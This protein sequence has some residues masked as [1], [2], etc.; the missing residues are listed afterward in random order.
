LSVTH[1]FQILERSILNILHIFQ[2]LERSILKILIN[3]LNIEQR[4]ER[5]QKLF[6]KWK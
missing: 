4:T 5:K 6:F 1:I 3:P 2:I